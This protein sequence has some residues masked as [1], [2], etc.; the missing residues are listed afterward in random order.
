MI[1]IES[2]LS[3]YMILCGCMILFNL[4]F[5]GY[6]RLEINKRRYKSRKLEYLIKKENLSDK[7]LQYIIHKLKNKNYLMYYYE[8]I[9]K[10]N[11]LPYILSRLAGIYEKYD[12]IDKAYLAYILS[13]QRIE[14]QL[15]I[16]FLMICIV[17]KSVYCREKALQALY[18]IGNEEHIISAYKLL[19]RNDCTHHNK[20]L[21]DGLITSNVNAMVLSELLWKSFKEFNVDIKIAIIN[22]FKMMNQD[23]SNQ[24]YEVL[25]DDNQH[26][27][28]R[29]ALIRYFGKYKYEPAKQLMIHF[30]R[31][32]REMSWEYLVN[33]ARELRNYPDEDTI[34]SLKGALRN[35]NWHVRV[36]AAE[37]LCNMEK[38]GV[39]IGNI[40]FVNNRYGEEILVYIRDK[41]LMKVGE[42]SD[43]H[44]RIS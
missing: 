2:V 39:P 36:N 24:F 37:S 19:T 22:Y 15:I 32:E 28:V 43:H 14:T 34:E 38:L 18:I 4:V 42:H 17:G 40:D 33:A 44:K 1:N 12:D 9:Q 30:L 29:L 21:S 11:Q 31:N 26:K 16:S 8:D 13:L 6:D 7:E 10:M 3:I 5:L 27:E 23:Y 41:E 35:R 20:L 25:T